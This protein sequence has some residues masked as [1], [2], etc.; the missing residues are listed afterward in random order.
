M[1]LHLHY[2][3]VVDVMKCVGSVST[4]N[5]RWIC[6]E[7]RA[8]STAFK[9]KLYGKPKRETEE[10]GREKAEMLVSMWA[11]HRVH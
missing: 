8:M 7:V 4:S 11:G 6:Q 9:I 10:K 5:H 1:V 2:L 3:I